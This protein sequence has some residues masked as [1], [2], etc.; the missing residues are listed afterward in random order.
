MLS[1]YEN[2]ETE[3]QRRKEEQ[4][5]AD[6]KQETREARQTSSEFADIF[7]LELIEEQAGKKNRWGEDTLADQMKRDQQKKRE[8]QKVDAEASKFFPTLGES[9]QSVHKPKSTMTAAALLG[10]SAV[11]NTESTSNPAI[12]SSHPMPNSRSHPVT[13]NVESKTQNTVQTNA[14]KSNRNKNKGKTKLHLFG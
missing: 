5:V 7:E 4:R 13:Q 3:R 14:A 6:K 2:D 11:E 10:N 9:F 1:V 8:K 12:S